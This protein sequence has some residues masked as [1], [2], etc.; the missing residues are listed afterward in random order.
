L[1]LAF[2]RDHA[3]LRNTDGRI[4]L[5]WK[6]ESDLATFQ[7]AWDYYAAQAR[8]ANLPVCAEKAFYPQLEPQLMGLGNDAEDEKDEQ[9]PK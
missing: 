9:A 3:V 4:E 6:G 5:V 1:L 8:A 2:V 7:S